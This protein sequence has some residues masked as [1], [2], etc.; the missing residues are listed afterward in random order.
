M[1]NFFVEHSFRVGFLVRGG[2]APLACSCAVRHQRR[3]PMRVF[4]CGWHA[5]L[6]IWNV[7][8]NWYTT[9]FG[10]YILGCSVNHPQ[11]PCSSSLFWEQ[12][13]LARMESYFRHR[14]Q[15]TRD[16][17]KVLIILITPLPGRISWLLMR[18]NSLRLFFLG[19]RW[20]G[21]R[22]CEL[23]GIFIQAQK[24]MRKGGEEG[25]DWGL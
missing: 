22:R 6:Y 25:G 7:Y 23:Q 14:L 20:R 3:L 18:A 2:N 1:T 16:S 11:E 12:S 15:W 4:L 8:K 10:Y 21:R 13:H 24:E 19:L 5:H 17:Y 9:L